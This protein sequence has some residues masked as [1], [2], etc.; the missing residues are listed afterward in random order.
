MSYLSHLQCSHCQTNYSAEQLIRLCPECGYPL[1]A[2]YDLEEA[3]SELDRDQIEARKDGL[4]RYKE[5]L[6]VRDEN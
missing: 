6:P 2:R 4:W 1:L 3:K 5:M